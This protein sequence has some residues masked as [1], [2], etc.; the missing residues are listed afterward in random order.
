MQTIYADGI[1]NM[2]LVDGVVRVD[3]VN[4]TSVEK[5]KEPNVRPNATL[6][7]SLPALIRVHDQFG[8]M[9]DKMVSDGILTKNQQPQ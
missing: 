6:A 2:L 3:L 9:I 1:A 5:D 8:K 7:M 4:V